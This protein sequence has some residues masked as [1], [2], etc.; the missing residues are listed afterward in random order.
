[1]ML[2]FQINILDLLQDLSFLFG[3]ISEELYFGVCGYKI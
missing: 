2:A 1:M 3:L